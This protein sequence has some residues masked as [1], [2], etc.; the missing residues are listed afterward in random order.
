MTNLKQNNMISEHGAD[1]LTGSFG[2]ISNDLITRM[3]K[4]RSKG[5]LIRNKYSTLLRKFA[6]TLNFYSP[7]AYRYVRQVFNL[8]LP[9][10][11][12]LQTWYRSVSGEPGFTGESFDALA[13]QVEQAKDKQ[14][15]ILCNLTI[16]EMAIRKQVEWDGSKFRGYTDIGTN[17][18]DDTLPVASEAL[19][20]MVVALDA[21]WKMPVGYFLISGLSGVEKANLVRDCISKLHDVG[22]RVTS[23]TCD[24]ASSNQSM[25]S[26][27]GARMTAANPQP[28]F[29][30]PS[31]TNNHVYVILDICHMLK[32]IRNTF[33]SQELYDNEGQPIKWHF[34]KTLHEIQDSSGLRAGNKLKKTHIEWQK[35]KMKV[36]LAAQTL[37]TSVA[38]ALQFCADKGIEGFLGSA[39]T[40]NFIRK[41][42]R[43]FDILNS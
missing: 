26:E 39:A 38:D 25:F 40:I 41:I 33:A 23:L 14:K 7:K 19:V 10:P 20:F 36:S 13:K 8:A 1:V 27:L 35:Q 24:G 37:S 32:L 17:V 4:D 31:D 12:V 42:D 16:D 6:L 18:D 21:S 11:S 15:Q 2:D 28:W 22:V 34:F 29:L 30:H 9:H 3:M 5:H 43:L